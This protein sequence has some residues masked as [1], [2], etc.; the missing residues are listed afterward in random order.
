ME[1]TE[2]NAAMGV[3]VRHAPLVRVQPVVYKDPRQQ[4]YHE[5][6]I[7]MIRHIALA[8]MTTSALLGC[9]DPD[10]VPET[11]ISTPPPAQDLWCKR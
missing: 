3:G 10:V 6:L 2:I 7:D 4:I 8:V 1:R 11:H 9:A 5:A